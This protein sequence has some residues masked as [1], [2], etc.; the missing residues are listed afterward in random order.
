MLEKYQLERTTDG[1]QILTSRKRE[2][3]EGKSKRM[4]QKSAIRERN[5]L[6]GI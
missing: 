5:G 6:R 1:I 3:I 2:A 4:L